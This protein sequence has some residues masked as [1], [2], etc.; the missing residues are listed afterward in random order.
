MNQGAGIHA[1]DTEVCHPAAGGAHG[2]EL[3]NLGRE[4]DRQ[5]LRSGK[6]PAR[7]MMNSPRPAPNSSSRGAVRLKRAFGSRLKTGPSQPTITPAAVASASSR[8]RRPA[9]RILAIRTPP[10]CG[11][12]RQCV[13]LRQPELTDKARRPR[14]MAVETR[15]KQKNQLTQPLR[16]QYIGASMSP[17]T[18]RD[19][20]RLVDA[21]EEVLDTFDQRRKSVLSTSALAILTGSPKKKRS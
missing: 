18:G 10:R 17:E 9:L 1:D 21:F 14:R 11:A 13:Q 16:R 12:F 2:Q 3:R 7:S 4:L 6:A 20:R 5:E 15:T 19:V 8:Q